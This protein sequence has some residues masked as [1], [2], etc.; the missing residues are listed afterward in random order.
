MHTHYKSCQSCAMPFKSDPQGGGTNADGSKSLMYC[1]YC[2]QGGAFT[3]PEF[4]AAQM[5]QFV[6]GKLQEMGPLY[7]LF[8]GLFVKG[9]PKLQRWKQ[10]GAQ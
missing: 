5:Q 4:T 6:K 1:S 9:I 2:Y 8:A 7:R 3:Q 10:Q